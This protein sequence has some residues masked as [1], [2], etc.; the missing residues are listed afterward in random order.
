MVT[1]YW[2]GGE[3]GI[4][5]QKLLVVIMIRTWILH[6]QGKGMASCAGPP[7]VV[8]NVF[9]NLKLD[10]EGKID[11]LVSSEYGFKI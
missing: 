8:E 3:L 1:K 7:H 9:R 10:L 5:G 2:E 4:I 11:E 6:R